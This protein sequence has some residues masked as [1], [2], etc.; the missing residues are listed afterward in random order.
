VTVVLED[1]SGNRVE[2]QTAS[3]SA[4]TQAIEG[5]PALGTKYNDTLKMNDM[6]PP[7]GTW[8]RMIAASFK[9]PDEKLQSRKRFIVKIEEV[10]GK[11]AEIS[12]K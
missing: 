9:L 8:D 1:A 10:D 11:V 3:D 2:G 5:I 6:V 7:K 4:A 12:E